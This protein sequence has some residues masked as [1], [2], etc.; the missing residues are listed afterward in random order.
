MLQR[1]PSRV[2]FFKKP[3]ATN[4]SKENSSNVEKKI[5]GKTLR[6][7]KVALKSKENMKN[8]EARGKLAKHVL[9]LENDK[10]VKY[11]EIND[12]SLL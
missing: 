10:R 5:D 6:S 2:P 11:E 7:V 1:A 9:D 4:G 8:L 3:Q 12:D